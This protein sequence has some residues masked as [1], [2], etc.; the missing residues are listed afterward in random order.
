MM[1]GHYLSVPMHSFLFSHL[2]FVSVMSPCC[3]WLIL[4][5]DS[6]ARETR[7]FDWWAT[8]SW[9]DVC[10]HPAINPVSWQW[11]N[12]APSYSLTMTLS[13]VILCKH[14]VEK[15]CIYFLWENWYFPCHLCA[16]ESLLPE[17]THEAVF[18][19]SLCLCVFC[20]LHFWVV[21]V[22]LFSVREHYH[23][24]HSELQTVSVQSDIFVCM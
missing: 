2:L 20:F 10:V 13:P 15:L 22:S 3:P 12:R 14:W 16:Y 8:S 23:E 1:Q 5:F 11:K 18:F 4:H 9:D 7:D 19:L 6:S 21:W 17:V 24:T